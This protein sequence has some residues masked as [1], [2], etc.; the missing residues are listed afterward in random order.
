MSYAISKAAIQPTSGSAL[1]NFT[2]TGPWA[3]MIAPG[4]TQLLPFVQLE[5]LQAML[6]IFQSYPEVSGNAVLVTQIITD[7]KILTSQL[8]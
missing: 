1:L 8:L 6:P 4:A 2:K 5:I 3:A 7:I